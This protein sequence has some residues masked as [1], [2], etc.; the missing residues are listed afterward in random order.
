MTL[1][2]IM[3]GFS[4]PGICQFN[5]DDIHDSAFT[6]SDLTFLQSSEYD[7]NRNSEISNSSAVNEETPNDS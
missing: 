6:S 5:D 4:A 7:D 2:N 3:S 1:P